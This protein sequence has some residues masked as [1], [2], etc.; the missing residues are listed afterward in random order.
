MPAPPRLHICSA[1]ETEVVVAALIQTPLKKMQYRAGLL[2]GFL[3]STRTRFCR[4]ARL[5]ARL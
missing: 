5:G 1:T 3:A 2:E 4:N